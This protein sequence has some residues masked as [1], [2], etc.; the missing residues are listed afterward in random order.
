MIAKYTGP[1]LDEKARP[2]DQLKHGR[3]A[4]QHAKDHLEMQPGSLAGSRG[5]SPGVAAVVPVS[6]SSRDPAVVA[7][8][9][10]QQAMPSLLSPPQQ[11]HHQSSAL[12][13]EQAEHSA[14]PGMEEF[15]DQMFSLPSWNDMGGG[16]AN[17]A[18]RAP[19]DYNAVGAA[20][21]TR[22]GVDA[23]KL[24]TMSL[25][26]TGLLGSQHTR[27]LQHG[28]PDSAHVG[29]SVIYT[30][31]DNLLSGP[32]VRSLQDNSSAAPGIGS[33]GGGGGGGATTLTRS[34]SVGSSGSEGSD[35]PQSPPPIA[36]TWRQPYVGGVPPLPLGLGQ[37]KPESL[38][39]GD[40]GEAHLLGKRCRDDDEVS[41]RETHSGNN[42]REGPQGLFASFAGAQIAQTQVPRPAGQPSHQQGNGGS[43][44]GVQTGQ[45]VPVVYGSQ[46]VS[47]QPQA[48]SGVVAISARPRVR[49]RRG[50]A[51]DPHSIAE[52][53][54]RERIAE[55]MK[56]LQELVP[57]SN[58]TDK[59]SML[60]EI[61]DYVKFLQLQVKVLSMSRLGGAGAVAPLAA[62]LPSEGPSNYVTATMGRSNGGPGPSQDGLA[63]TERQVARLM[64]EDM[65]S[66]MQYLQSKGLCLMPISLATAI[67]STNSRSQGGN[68]GL[69]GSGER[70]RSEAAAAAAV[71]NSS[72]SLTGGSPS[73]TGAIDGDSGNKSGSGAPTNAIKDSRDASVEKTCGGSSSKQSPKAKTQFKGKEE[74]QRRSQ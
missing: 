46:T 62:D 47:A 29:D 55:R 11:Q 70:Q 39:R 22:L 20:A 53:L 4:E 33:R 41:M 3:Q 19:C 54:R 38:L 2:A 16:G 21:A 72:G 42:L 56:A 60:D 45:A 5:Q 9:H 73:G 65:G 43:S 71:I 40:S 44:Q 17:N 66:A 59:A 23:Q 68:Q 32:R 74:S 61:I 10:I 63:L 31:D 34:P 13:F 27:D 24:F 36:P 49:A 1:G 35:G 8:T 64:E 18:G 14:P 12:Q 67:S 26:P 51:T 48:G 28:G 7:S 30:N 6:S 57:N 37:A 52:R 25:L 15:L 69:Q 58:K 50:Q